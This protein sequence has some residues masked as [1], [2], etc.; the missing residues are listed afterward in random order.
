MI[1]KPKLSPRNLSEF[2]RKENLIKEYYT[3]YLALELQKRV[4]LTN[5]IKEM[6]LSD[7]KVY[8]VDNKSGI[9]SEVEQPEPNKE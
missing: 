4:W 5:V 1:R 3:V 8:N 2:Q 6:G 7:E 9:I